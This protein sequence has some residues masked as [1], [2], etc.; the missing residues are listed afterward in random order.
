MKSALSI[1]AT[2]ALVLAPLLPHLG[3][4]C[5]CQKRELK[6]KHSCCAKKKKA[7]SDHAAKRQRP[8]P[9]DVARGPCGC[10]PKGE[11][12]VGDA[13]ASEADIT[14]AGP[15]V[16]HVAYATSLRAPSGLTLRAKPCDARAPPGGPP[17][18]LLH[19]AFLI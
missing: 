13:V 18:H 5:D 4:E 7:Q 11:L 10:C 2:L 1:V 14:L 19:C 9:H 16:T 3:H 17:L 12:S 6:T 8:R 15:S